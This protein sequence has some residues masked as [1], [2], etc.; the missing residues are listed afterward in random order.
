MK[1]LVLV[2]QSSNSPPCSKRTPK[3]KFVVALIGNFSLSFSDFD[4]CD[5][6]SF[7]VVNLILIFLKNSIREPEMKLLALIPY[8]VSGLFGSLIVAL[9]HEHHWPWPVI[10]VIKYPIF[11]IEINRGFSFIGC[12]VTSIPAIATGYTIDSYKPISGVFPVWATLNKYV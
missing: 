8:I 4:P 7:H 11:L 12:R 3:Q 1:S 9:T 2:P 6:R 10:I 5:L